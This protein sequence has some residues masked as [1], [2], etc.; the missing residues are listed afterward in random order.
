MMHY[1]KTAKELNYWTQLYPNYI[2]LPSYIS[3][4]Y[5]FFVILESFFG[6]YSN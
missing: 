4:L 6:K 2:F 3:Y 5:D 1:E